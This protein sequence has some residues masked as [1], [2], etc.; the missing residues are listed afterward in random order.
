MSAMVG[1]NRGSSAARSAADGVSIQRAGAESVGESGAN[2]RTKARRIKRVRSEILVALKMLYPTALQAHQLMRSLLVLFPQMEWDQFRRDLAYLSE[3]QYV[4]RV[5][6]DAER[7]PDL[8][9][10]RKR[11]FR[12][13][14]AG[15]E[16]ADH[17]VED[18]ALD[19]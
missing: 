1:V 13:T 5:V 10:W 19:V 14:S 15:L 2:H 7:A 4:Q 6:S 3:K 11:W 12:L 9:P 18:P 8:T 17:C 16:V